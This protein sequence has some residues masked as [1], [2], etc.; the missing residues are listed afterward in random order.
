MRTAGLPATTELGGKDLVTTALAPIIENFPIV[1]L[2]IIT[3]PSPHQTFLSIVTVPELC[4][5]LSDGEV[6]IASLVISSWKW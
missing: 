4:N 2:G 5:F 6:F 3:A 1:T